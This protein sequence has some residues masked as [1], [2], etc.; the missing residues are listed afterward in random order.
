M[1]QS[2]ENIDR[3]LFLFL[4]NMHNSFWDSLMFTISR[5]TV[6]IPLYVFLILYFVYTQKKKAILSVLTIALLV[7]LADYT[8][9][10]LFKNVF[11]RYRPCHN[12]EIQN[13][14]H[15]VNNHCGGQYGLYLRMLAM[16]FP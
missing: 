1:L 6:S 13:L 11:L 10:H 5:S 12:L 2:I 7:G 16:C 3:S 14:I 8:S 4:N 9:V 15:L